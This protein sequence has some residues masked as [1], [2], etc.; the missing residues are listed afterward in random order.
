VAV[1]D[2]VAVC[3]FDSRAYW[4]EE[5]QPFL[6]CQFLL[7]CVFRDP[8]AFDVLHHKVWSAIVRR[9]A[10]EEARNIGVLELGQNLALAPEP[11][12]DEIGIETR[13]NQLDCDL[14]FI[15]LVV[16]A[17]Q[18]D[19][20]HSAAPQLVDQS[21]WADLAA[22]HRAGA[23]LRLTRVKLFYSLLHLRTHELPAGGLVA[24]KQR[25]DLRL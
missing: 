8:D 22:G 18:I 14:R 19:R 10:V 24:G 20:A 1:N 16:T 6:N 21:V 17:R 25:G 7:F 5:P 12:Q 3:M 15:L 9:A 4:Q 23:A 2:E 13:P 11:A